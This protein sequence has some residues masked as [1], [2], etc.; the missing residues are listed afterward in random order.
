MFAVSPEGSQEWKFPSKGET[1][2]EI[3]AAPAVGSD[4]TIYFGTDGWTFYALNRDGSLRWRFITQ[5]QTNDRTPLIARSGLIYFAADEGIRALTPDGNLAWTFHG[6]DDV[7]AAL[8]SDGTIY[9]S[10]GSQLVAIDPGR[11]SDARTA[12]SVN[13]GAVFR[14]VNSELLGLPHVA[15]IGLA[16]STASSVDRMLVRYPSPLGVTQ[17]PVQSQQ[18]SGFPHIVILVEAVVAWDDLPEFAKKIPRSVQGIPI[19]VTVEP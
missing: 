18:P 15:R 7:S 11:Q 1:D 8:G 3:D 6:D 13:P 12:H 14:R 9:A 17:E 4:G 16:I 5:T 10:K 19:E 2:G